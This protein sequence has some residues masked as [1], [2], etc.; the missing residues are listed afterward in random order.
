MRTGLLDLSEISERVLGDAGVS[1]PEIRALF[2]TSGSLMY[3]NL[4]AEATQVPLER[5]YKEGLATYG[6]VHACDNFIGL[7][8]Y[9]ETKRPQGGDHYMMMGWSPYVVSASVV[10]VVG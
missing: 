9:F 8:D 2:G 6:H 4:M 10:R 3:L 7:K 1:P 5:V